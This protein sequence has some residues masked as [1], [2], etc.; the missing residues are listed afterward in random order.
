MERAPGPG[1]T[2]D[3]YLLVEEV[4]RGGMGTVYRARRPDLARDVALKLL[5]PGAR[6]ERLQVE[7][8]TMA[9]LAHPAIVPVHAVGVEPRGRWYLV[10]EWVEGRSLQAR[11]EAE[12]PLPV[13]EVLEV[14]RRLSEALAHAH[15]RGVLH[16]DLKPGNLLQRRQDGQV[17][18]TDFGLARDLTDPTRLSR[19]GQLLGTPGF[20]APEQLLGDAQR[21]DARCDVYGVGATLYALLTGAPPFSGSLVEMVRATVESSPQRPSALRAGIPPALDAVCAR[22]LEKDPAA[23]YPS[24]EALGA[25]LEAAAVAPGP[26][27]LG[28][29]RRVRWLVGLL[30]V[31]APAALVWARGRAREQAQ[32]RVAAL[33]DQAAA[34]AAEG[35]FTPWAE[36]VAAAS[37]L[38][39]TDRALRAQVEEVRSAQRQTLLRRLRAATREEGLRPEVLSGLRG[40]LAASARD[41]PEA[42]ELRLLLVR[43]LRQ[44]GLIEE[45][46]RALPEEVAG[47]TRAEL[48]LERELLLERAGDAPAL[49]RQRELTR[50]TG[51]AWARELSEAGRMLASPRRS[52]EALERIRGA[53]RERP[54]HLHAL[55]LELYALLR[56]GQHRAAVALFERARRTHPLEPELPLLEARMHLRE[57]RFERCVAALNEVAH[58]TG[59]RLLE[60][61][62]LGLRLRLFQL[63]DPDGVVA[64]AD[65][66]LAAH[67]GPDPSARA[68]RAELLL[69]RG[70]ARRA[71]GDPLGAARD[72]RAAH[73]VDPARL[74]T[75]AREL[76]YGLG[77]RVLLAVGVA[78][79]EAG[80]VGPVKPVTPDERRRIV[81]SGLPRGIPPGARL[82][83]EEAYLGACA[84]TPW[85]ELEARLQAA[86][87]AA[88]QEAA[89]ALAAARLLTW[90]ERLPAAREALEAA[91]RLAGQDAALRLEVGRLEA[92]VLRRDGRFSQALARLRAL[93]QEDPQ[94]L[95]GRWAAAEAALIRGDPA[96]AV[97]LAGRALERDPQDHLAQVTLA[98]AHTAADAAEGLSRANALWA[99]TGYLDARVSQ[100]RTMGAMERAIQKA[101]FGGV[102][103]MQA[104][105]LGHSWCEDARFASAGPGP[106][107]TLL[108]YV[109]PLPGDNWAGKKA[110]VARLAGEARARGGAERVELGLF[111]AVQGADQ[112]A[113]REQTL[114]RLRALMQ[115][116]PW[117]PLPRPVDLMFM[118]RWGPD[119]V[120][121]LHA[122]LD[123]ARAR[124]RESA[125]W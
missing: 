125:G 95:I 55:R 80:V 10:M 32:G 8:R 29:R 62:Q 59:G 91:A 23:R 63:L 85:E 88:P 117:M 47:P 106:A 122:E 21:V 105:D 34:R 60:A 78:A 22:C 97:D 87:A 12:G 48:A 110:M 100:V 2:I 112:G 49:E 114:E 92:E 123:A 104:V 111:E 15:A 44:R 38:A 72:W 3:G 76:P 58:L 25:A 81:L 64:E 57:R 82:P 6:P 120:N 50:R 84:A 68:A 7:A 26:A 54:D 13:G 52:S 94:G 75:C 98:A 17:L 27:R 67:A 4:G 119:A 45:A 86:R 36:A 113:T 41:E 107:L 31:L 30:L 69:L 43:Y 70:L 20:A 124:S 102:I 19:T 101:L 103:D 56:A 11:L 46:L 37:S 16:R 51:P 5:E 93:I 121:Q 53:A 90:R 74:L 18:V 115:R 40:L 28:R 42:D 118:F 35:A 9:R 89:V 83:L 109:A 24:M 96:E 66:F 33:I 39:G 73:E 65:R 77:P 99:A 79:A 71:E 116:E 14:G 108:T 1:A 61:A